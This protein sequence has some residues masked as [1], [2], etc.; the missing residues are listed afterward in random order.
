M[1]TIAYSANDGSFNRK[2]LL[3]GLHADH[4]PQDIFFARTQ[5]HELSETAWE[6]RIKPLQSW[7][8]FVLWG[9]VVLMFAA[10]VSLV[11]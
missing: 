10:C 9:I 11:H 5:S 6:S 1:S 7:G 4:R 2:A 3:I 8:P